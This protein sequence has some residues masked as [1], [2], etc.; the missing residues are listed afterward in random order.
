M[1]SQTQPSSVK[2]WAIVPAAGAGHRMQSSIPKQY[3][4]I[5]GCCM[6]EHSLTRLL[7]AEWI[8]GIVVALAENDDYWQQLQLANNP[9]ITTVV[10]GDERVD[11]VINALDS[12]QGQLQDDDFILVHD[13]ARPC[14]SNEDIEKLHQAMLGADAASG[15]VLA[16]KLTDTIKRDDGNS[17]VLKTVPRQGLWRALTPQIFPTDLL[18]KALKQTQSNVSPDI[19]DEASAVE[20]L[21]YSPRLI[22]GRSD[23]IKVTTDGDVHLATLIL[24]SQRD[25]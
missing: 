22:Q 18:N 19:T 8:T 2:C 23:N 11:S 10:G 1:N 3:I 21:G 24:Q 4:K 17:S 6:I 20:L 7:A 25:N 16:D 5:G 9:R 15:V 14:I 13:A 12:I